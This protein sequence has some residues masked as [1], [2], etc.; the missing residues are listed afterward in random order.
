ML[1]GIYL[2]RNI[3]VATGKELSLSVIKYLQN[4]LMYNF[5]KK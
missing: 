5:E 4:V 2:R 1:S 3:L